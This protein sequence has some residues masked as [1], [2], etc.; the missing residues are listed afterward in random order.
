MSL[1]VGDTTKFKAGGVGVL[2][3]AVGNDGTLICETFPPTGVKAV[4][5][6]DKD[7]KGLFST[8][9]GFENGAD[10]EIPLNGSIKLIFEEG[11]A[12]YWVNIK[13]MEKSRIENDVVAVFY[14]NE[15]SNSTEFFTRSEFLK[16]P[17]YGA[18]R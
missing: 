12:G 15:G 17:I 10:I 5:I 7:G 16:S 9:P 14:R 3:I 6:C 11:I 18:L 2:V 4:Y 8:Q 1:R 13:E